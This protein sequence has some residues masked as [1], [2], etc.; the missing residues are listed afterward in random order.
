MLTLRRSS[1]IS[2]VFAR[3]IIPPSQPLSA[4]RH[5]RM[6]LRVLCHRRFSDDG[7]RTNHHSILAGGK[8]VVFSS[9][10]YSTRPA[11]RGHWWGGRRLGGEG[12]EAIRGDDGRLLRRREECFSF[13]SREPTRLC[14]HSLGHVRISTEEEEESGREKQQGEEGRFSIEIKNIWR[15]SGAEWKE[16]NRYSC[17][18]ETGGLKEPE[19][20]KSEKRNDETDLFGT[21]SPEVMYNV[22][23]LY[24]NETEGISDRWRRM[25]SSHMRS[26][27]SPFQSSRPEVLV[28]EVTGQLKN[29][30]RSEENNEEEDEEEEGKN[31]DVERC[32]KEWREINEE[33]RIAVMNVLTSPVNS[34][35]NFVRASA[36]KIFLLSQILQR[37]VIV[38]PSPIADRPYQQNHPMNEESEHLVPGHLSAGRSPDLFSVPSSL[39]SEEQHERTLECSGTGIENRDDKAIS[40]RDVKGKRKERGWQRK[41]NIKL[42]LSNEEQEIIRRAA[43]TAQEAVDLASGIPVDIVDNYAYYERPS[44]F[45]SE[46]LHRES[47]Y[48][49]LCRRYVGHLLTPTEAVQEEDGGANNNRDGK[50]T[51]DREKIHMH[52]KSEKKKEGTDTLLTRPDKKLTT[53][54]EQEEEEKQLHSAPSPF[55]P[56]TVGDVLARELLLFRR[57]NTHQQDDG[58]SESRG[59][60]CSTENPS[61]SAASSSPSVYTALDLLQGEEQLIDLGWLARIASVRGEGSLRE[62]GEKQN[63]RR[64][65]EEADKKRKHKQTHG[66][67]KED[68][69]AID[70]GA[71]GS[72]LPFFTEPRI[73]VMRVLEPLRILGYTQCT[74]SS[75][76]CD[77]HFRNLQ[78][79]Q[80]RLKQHNERESSEPGRSLDSTK[81]SSFS[82]SSS[83]R[84]TSQ[85]AASFPSVSPLQEDSAFFSN[86]DSKTE[87][88]EDFLLETSWPIASFSSPSPSSPWECHEIPGVVIKNVKDIELFLLPPEQKLQARGTGL[89]SYTFPGVSS[90]YEELEENRFHPQE[91]A[92]HRHDSMLFGCLYTSVDKT[93]KRPH[94][95]HRAIFRLQGQSQAF[96]SSLYYEEKKQKQ[97]IPTDEPTLTLLSDEV[98]IDLEKDT[99]RNEA[100]REKET[101]ERKRV[102]CLHLSLNK[103]SDS[104]LFLIAATSR[105]RTLTWILSPQAP[106]EQPHLL[107]DTTPHFCIP[108]NRHLLIFDV[109]NFNCVSVYTYPL[110]NL[111][112]HVSSSVSVSQQA[113]CVSKGRQLPAP[114]LR[115]FPPSPSP[116]FSSSQGNNG[117]RVFQAEGGREE[118]SICRC[119]GIRKRQREEEASVRSLQEHLDEKEGKRERFRNNQRPDHSF[120]SLL[121]HVF[122]IPSFLL[123]DV[124]CNASGLVIY[125]IRPPCTPAMFGVQFNEER[126]NKTKATQ[127]SSPFSFSPTS[128]HTSA[129]CCSSV[130]MTSSFP[131]VSV[132]EIV[133]TQWE[134]ARKGGERT[135][136]VLQPGVNN[137]Y[138]SSLLSF[139]FQSPFRPSLQLSL[140]LASGKLFSKDIQ[141]VDVGFLYF[142]SRTFLSQYFRYYYQHLYCPFT[143]PS[144]SVPVPDSSSSANTLSA[145]RS[146]SSSPLP[147]LYSSRAKTTWS[148]HHTSASPRSGLIK[149][150]IRLIPSCPSFGSSQVLYAPSRDGIC[151]IPITLLLPLNGQHQADSEEKER[152]GENKECLRDDLLRR[153]SEMSKTSKNSVTLNPDR[154][155]EKSKPRYSSVLPISFFHLLKESKKDGASHVPR[156]RESDSSAFSFLPP[157]D[158]LSSRA[159]STSERSPTFLS[160]CSPSFPAHPRPLLLH[161]YGCYKR[162]QSLWFSAANVFLLSLGWMIGFVHT[163]G[164]GAVEGE[165]STCG[166]GLKKYQVL[167]DMEDACMYLVANDLTTRPYLFLKCA[168]A[169]GLI[170]GSFLA[171]QKMRSW[172]SGIIIRQGFLDVHSAMCISPCGKQETR[173]GD[174]NVDRALGEEIGMAEKEGEREDQEG[175]ENTFVSHTP[176]RRNGERRKASKQIEYGGAEEGE[177]DSLRELEELEWGYCGR[178][179]REK[180]PRNGSRCD[181]FLES[182]HLSNILSYSPCSNFHPSEHFLFHHLFGG[183]KRRGEEEIGK[184]I[185]FSLHPHR[186]PGLIHRQPVNGIGPGGTSV[187]HEGKNELDSEAA[188]FPSYSFSSSFYGH[189]SLSPSKLLLVSSMGDTR[190]PVY[191]SVKFL[192]KCEALRRLYEKRKK[193]NSERVRDSVRKEGVEVQERRERSYPA[194][195]S[196]RKREEEKGRWRVR[197]GYHMVPTVTGETSERTPRVIDQANCMG[198]KGKKEKRKD[199]AG[200]VLSYFRLGG[201]D[202]GHVGRCSPLS[203]FYD[204][205]EEICFLMNLLE[206]RLA[207]VFPRSEDKE[208]SSTFYRSGR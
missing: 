37:L 204:E 60:R 188:N 107:A 118:S 106:L 185:V 83:C 171:F 24:H 69:K 127:S 16:R 41:H 73:G 197:A 148:S 78:C 33:E 121:E 136:G 2:G 1:H 15:E 18:R 23:V 172:F 161:A 140:D 50:T 128:L 36:S 178:H 126:N 89:M 62:G 93:T 142:S 120:S 117:P 174:E 75:E 70:A 143:S 91:H 125:G 63:K 46:V 105:E 131:D 40:E 168:S 21:T 208:R 55:L 160:S 201:P 64:E 44:S 94:Q 96:H 53:T 163:R 34:Y 196:G 145:F 104:S 198:D 182:Q 159:K 103:S 92:Q 48:P 183:G 20:V 101:E 130:S 146:S 207:C 115:F 71:S 202:E 156:A 77:L 176:D 27:F 52:V 162:P 122:T 138:S 32:R 147:S 166:R 28:E 66:D 76:I 8:N 124:D 84:F 179:R 109:A 80:H 81:A 10:G 170:G 203:H 165:E 11:A 42:A 39:Q 13:A 184:K 57:S 43:E 113:H 3:S 119:T 186:Y 72:S 193:T 132:K 195:K 164:E 173:D 45:S 116:S 111:W 98:L 110:Q 90:S 19:N 86:R 158:S 54:E 133:L 175:R 192:S 150:E 149:E 190:V 102:D 129:A 74:D 189:A 123:A 194:C 14:F 199:M 181:G 12:E 22:P 6:Y 51:Q 9:S 108:R 31:G 87:E 135:I 88:V 25:C 4:D 114:L 134:K 99:D 5:T 151:E 79:P 7:F 141:E 58:R 153:S 95:L 67:F 187:D 82:H 167:D 56:L 85:S 155:D 154:V 206:E 35:R 100:D 112:T 169:G 177:E 157:N 68:G 61:V 49:I 191:H 180:T 38:S 65:E 144:L 139:S 200:T 97:D 47:S 137:R 59:S 152:K 205:A 29:P 30:R 17:E 26:L